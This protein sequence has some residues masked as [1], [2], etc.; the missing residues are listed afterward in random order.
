MN[1]LRGISIYIIGMMGAGK[2]TVGELLAKELEYRFFDTDVLIERVKGKAIWEIF[3]TEGEPGFREIESQVLG[4]LSAY[5]QSVVATG[6]GIVL[7]PKNWSYLHHGIVV[8]LDLPVEQLYKRLQGDTTRPLLQE[9]DTLAKL[10]LL[11]S[12]RQPLY[13]QADLHITM[14]GE[15]TPEGVARRVLEEIPTIIK[16]E[17]KNREFN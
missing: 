2:T 1:N 3:K 8:W 11:L 13:S 10:R 9:V 4:S 5:L 6:G 7:R 17:V 16:P 15:E 12:D 14:T